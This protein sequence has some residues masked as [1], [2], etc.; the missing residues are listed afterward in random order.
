MRG[1]CKEEIH[2]GEGRSAAGTLG[3]ANVYEVGARNAGGS[4]LMWRWSELM[5]RGRGT[6]TWRK[7]ADQRNLGTLRRS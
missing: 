4:G 7:T 1:P 2:G 6:D 5:L 3:A